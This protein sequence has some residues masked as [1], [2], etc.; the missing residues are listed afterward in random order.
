MRQVRHGLVP[1]MSGAPMA[2]L[3]SAGCPQPPARKSGGFP[4][5]R[6]FWGLNEPSPGA[7]GGGT[8][9]GDATNSPPPAVT[10][11]SERRRLRVGAAPLRRRTR[12]DGLGVILA[13]ELCR[14]GPAL[15]PGLL[16]DRRDLGVGEE[17]LEALLVPVEDH[18]DPVVLRW[19]R[20]RRS[21]PWTRAACASRRPW[22]RRSSGKRS[23]SS[24]FVVAS[25]IS[26]SPQCAPAPLGPADVWRMRPAPPRT[27]GGFPMPGVFSA[28]PGRARARRGRRRPGC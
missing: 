28:A 11:G 12:R 18:P 26:C 20:E 24:T 25:I 15:V 13:A 10:G 6:K 27:S 4:M 1:L 19:D 14:L 21:N 22:S 5:A 3:T 17:A 23:K 2:R 8:L 7:A 16:N 9:G